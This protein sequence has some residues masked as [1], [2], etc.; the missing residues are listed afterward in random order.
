MIYFIKDLFPTGWL[1]I[2]QKA[3]YSERIWIENLPFSFIHKCDILKE[4]SIRY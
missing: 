1:D 2:Q 3:S 4:G